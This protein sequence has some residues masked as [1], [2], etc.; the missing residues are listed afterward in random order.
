MILQRSTLRLYLILFISYL[1]YCLSINYNITVSAFFYIL[2]L[3]LAL[4]YF[5]TSL[6]YAGYNQLTMSW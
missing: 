6:C 4:A 1:N 2:F 5:I 3:K